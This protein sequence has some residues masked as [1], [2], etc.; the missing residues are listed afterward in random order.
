MSK[1]DRVGNWG[2]ADVLLETTSQVMV[3]SEL[4]TTSSKDMQCNYNSVLQLVSDYEW[5]IC[6]KNPVLVDCMFKKLPN[7][8]QNWGY[9]K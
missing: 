5:I 9:Q 3:T 2:F 1:Q 7:K 6:F 4:A 8:G